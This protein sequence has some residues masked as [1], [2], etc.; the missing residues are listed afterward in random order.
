MPYYRAE[1]IRSTRIRHSLTPRRPW[2]GQ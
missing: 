2:P 1:L